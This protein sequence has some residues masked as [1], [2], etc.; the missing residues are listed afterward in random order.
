M[1]QMFGLDDQFNED[2]ILGKL[3]GLKDVIE[4]VNKQFKDPV[5]YLF[6]FPS[7]SFWP[8]HSIIFILC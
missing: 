4:E 8:V 2:A 7:V 6:L 1:T 3:E 5:R